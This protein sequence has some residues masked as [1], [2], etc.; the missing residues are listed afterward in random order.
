MP[1]KVI[2]HPGSAHRD[3]FL[4]VSI[5][6]AHDENV[7]VIER[8]NPSKK[9]IENHDV[10]VVDV[11]MVH[12]SKM[13][14]FDH[15]QL[16]EIECSLSLLL[17][18]L[19]LWDKSI[20]ALPWLESSVIDD[21]RGSLFLTQSLKIPHEVYDT[22]NSPIEEYI[23]D[24]FSKK[25]RIDS[26]SPLFIMMKGIGQRILSEI[27]EFSRFNNIVKEKSRFITIKEVPVLFFT[28]ERP[29]SVLKRVLDKYKKKLWGSGGIFILK[30]SRPPN[31]LKLLRIDD[32]PRV[33]FL[34]LKSL[35]DDRI[36]FIHING[37]MAVTKV[38]PDKEI[39]D[40]ISKSIK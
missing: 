28:E 26:E 13:N 11:G 21:A 2:C 4:S 34:L 9:E 18:H 38:I 25:S 3:D 16:E 1:N 27:K 24:D 12:D 6:L 8:K 29:T 23:L 14:A 10:W 40:L 37:F 35:N 22:L 39:E 36:N 15:H 17:K 32:D 5:I 7:N 19:Q 20:I 31:T 33:D 30:N